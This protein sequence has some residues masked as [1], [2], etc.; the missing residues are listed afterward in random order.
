MVCSFNFV[1]NGHLYVIGRD[2]EEKSCQTRRKVE[3]R[4]DLSD[5]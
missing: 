4:S 1:P 2:F 3:V 5:H